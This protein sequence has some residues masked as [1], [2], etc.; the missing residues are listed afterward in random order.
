MRVLRA[1]W[2]R[3]LG[4][5]RDGDRDRGRRSRSAAY[6]PIDSHHWGNRMEI[7]RHLV[8]SRSR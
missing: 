1:L 5:R 6:Q 4:D 8:T 2:R 7:H 3:L